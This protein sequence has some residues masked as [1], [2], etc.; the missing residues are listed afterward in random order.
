MEASEP[1]AQQQ[2]EDNLTEAQESEHKEICQTDLSAW[3]PFEMFSRKG[4]N[5][6]RTSCDIPG[7]TT[8]RIY[9]SINR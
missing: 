6:R 2:K 4:K 1:N 8:K 9:P 7:Q 5:K 3:N